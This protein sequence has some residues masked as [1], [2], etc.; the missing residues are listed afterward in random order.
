MREIGH[1]HGHFRTERCRGVGSAHAHVEAAA[2]A[3]TGTGRQSRPFHGV[4]CPCSCPLLRHR[5]LAARGASL[6]LPTEGQPA[7]T[8]REV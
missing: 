4:K 7:N 5:F 2:A 1:E 8:A 6:T 3:R